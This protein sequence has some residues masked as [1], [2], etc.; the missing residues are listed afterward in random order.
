MQYKEGKFHTK[1]SRVSLR[2][3]K[4][5]TASRFLLNEYNHRKYKARELAISFLQVLWND[6][7]TKKMLNTKIKERDVACLNTVKPQR[8]FMAL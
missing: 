2:L 4:H 8:L 6:V 5:L 7:S 1:L 3:I